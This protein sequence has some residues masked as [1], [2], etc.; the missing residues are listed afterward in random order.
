MR[1]EL[2]PANAG[3]PPSLNPKREAFARAYATHGNAA[4]AYRETFDVSDFRPSTVKQRAYELVHEPAVAARVREILAQAAEGTTISARARMVRLQD[5]VEADPG[6]LVR[7]VAESCRRCHGAGH[8]HQWIDAEEFAAALADARRR[9]VKPLPTA[10]G[11]Y[12]Y[13]PDHE[14][15]P[16][17]PACFGEGVR[18]VVVTPTD[19]LS[20]SARKL[21]KGV[22][23]KA[24]GEVEIRLH[25]QLEALDMLNR[26]Q[27]CYI[28]RTVSLNLNADIKPLKR[29][30]S[31]DE[32]L[33]I[34]QEVAPLPVVSEQ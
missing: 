34:M 27:G 23:Q 29:G 10:A 8:A 19:Q 3:R 22:R 7:V 28:D 9:R 15:H 6:E 5:I 11:G 4:R 31:V 20:P 14:P 25:D 32:A 24:S 21:L 18:R 30:M 13:R 1:S 26:M 33:A 16:D 2:V 12:G 17:C